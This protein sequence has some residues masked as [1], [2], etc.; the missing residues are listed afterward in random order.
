MQAV[1]ALHT[2]TGFRVEQSE[3]S[4]VDEYFNLYA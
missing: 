2:L 4:F 3:P 1:A